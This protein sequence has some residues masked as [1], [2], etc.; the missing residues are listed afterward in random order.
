MRSTMS[1][2]VSSMNT[3]SIGK[4]LIYL[5]GGRL[6]KED[7]VNHSVGIEMCKKIGEAVHVGDVICRVYFESEEKKDAA[8]PLLFD[9]ITIS[10]TYEK[11]PLVYTIM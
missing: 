9:S 11:N 5:G 3:F 2:F 4:A 7:S 10:D 8:L 6:K 1:G